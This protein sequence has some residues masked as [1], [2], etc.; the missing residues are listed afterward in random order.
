[1]QQKVVSSFLNICLFNLF[2][3]IVTSNWASSRQSSGQLFQA[4]CIALTSSLSPCPVE[5]DG[6]DPYRAID[7]CC[8]NLNTKDTGSTHTAFARFLD[9]AY[10]DSV[11]VP[12]GGLSPSSLPNARALS[13]AVH[14]TEQ[15][16][17]NKD[18]SLMVMQFGQ[19]LDHDITLTPEPGSSRIS[20][21]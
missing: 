15:I 19:F 20:L 4:T 17:G 18:A 13:K 11:E 1:M 9:P 10:E 2:F 5:C 3:F 7:G 12:R 21:R 16:V 14:R 6:S 8:N